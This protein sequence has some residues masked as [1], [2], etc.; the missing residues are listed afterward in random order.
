MKLIY[1]IAKY[2]QYIAAAGLVVLMMLQVANMVGRY[3]FNAPIQGT[4]DLGSY[5][6]LV[7]VSLGLGWAALEGRH[8]KVGLVMDRLPT[9]AQFVIDNI[10]LV[11]I[12]AVVVYV[13]YLNILAGATWPARVSSV[14]KI[15]YQPFRFI[16][17]GG[18]GILG[19]CTVVV[20]IEN[21][22]KLGDEK[23]GDHES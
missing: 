14:L 18:F 3:F 7:I 6:L 4:T 20:I 8:I 13:A 11:V 21:F 22:R 15:P 9:K 16:F 10:V 23:R 1:G 2:L 12:F 5:M 17:G 19:L